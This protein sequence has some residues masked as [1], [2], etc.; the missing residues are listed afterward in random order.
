MALQIIDIGLAP[1]DG[2]GDPIRTAYTKCNDNFT[3][4]YARTQT[5]VPTNQFGSEGDQAGMY[6]YDSQ[7]FYYCFANYDGSSGIWRRI[8]GSSF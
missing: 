6:A 4:L 7:Y 8:L 1:N 5:E 3:E 2:L